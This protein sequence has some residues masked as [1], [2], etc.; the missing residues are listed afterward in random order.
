MLPREQS[1]R[2][3][4]VDDERTIADTLVTIFSVRGY[5]ARGVYSAEDASTL[6]LTWAPDLAVIDVFLPRMNGVE[7]AVLVK[8][9]FPACR[10]ILFSGQPSARDVMNSVIGQEPPFELLAKPVHPSELLMWAGYSSL[11]Q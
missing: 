11:K 8:A 5:D 6:M 10:L 2:V 1:V 9:G 7:L 3:L 4:I